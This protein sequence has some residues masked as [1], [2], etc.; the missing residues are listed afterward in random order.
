MWLPQGA[1]GSGV[2]ARHAPCLYD[3]REQIS[4]K[5]GRACEPEVWRAR[6]SARSSYSALIGQSAAALA[7]PRM[8][9]G[10]RNQ[11]SSLLTCAA[12][13]LFP[14]SRRDQSQGVRTLASS[15]PCSKNRSKSRGNSSPSSP[16]SHGSSCSGRRTEEWGRRRMQRWRA[17]VRAPPRPA[18]R[19]ASRRVAHARAQTFSAA[20][21]CYRC[22][23]P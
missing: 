10:W 18:A 5:T 19:G 11:E 12:F 14:R 8:L 1:A 20:S 7:E 21:Y 3:A 2:S 16:I 9:I 15:S 23:G 6:E 17:S 13:L 4:T 22:C